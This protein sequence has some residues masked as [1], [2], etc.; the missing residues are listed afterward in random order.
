ML[1]WSPCGRRVTCRQLQSILQDQDQDL[2][3]LANEE[4]KELAVLQR[5]AQEKIEAHIQTPKGREA[6]EK[7]INQLQSRGVSREEATSKAFYFYVNQMK[8][9]EQEQLAKRFAAEK[10]EM[11]QRRAQTEKEIMEIE[12]SLRMI[13]G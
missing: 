4:A 11:T 1:V 9:A 2:Q 3:S 13:E 8:K 7:A 10:K 5:Q 6:L 12:E